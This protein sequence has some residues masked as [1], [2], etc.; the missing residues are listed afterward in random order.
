MLSVFKQGVVMLSVVAPQITAVKC[1]G[2]AG[3]SGKPPE[4]IIVILS[5]IKTCSSNEL[6]NNEWPNPPSPRYS[7]CKQSW[8]VPKS[9]NLQT[10]RARLSDINQNDNNQNSINYYNFQRDDT[11]QNDIQHN[12]FQQN[13]INHTGNPYKRRRLSTV[14]LL[15]KVVCL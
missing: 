2:S 7:F 3:P 15:I 6:F 14:D 9:P 1:F 13:D 10:F 8:L 11:H 4:L 5:D 12:N